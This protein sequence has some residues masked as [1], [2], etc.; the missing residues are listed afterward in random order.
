MEVKEQHEVL[1]K[2]KL[3]VNYVNK[4]YSTDKK[5]LDVGAGHGSTSCLLSSLG[6]DV[7][8]MDLFSNSTIERL[9]NNNVKVIN[10]YFSCE[11][12]ISNYDLIVGLHC[13]GA[14]ELIIK[15]S[16]INDKEFLVTLC[17][18]RK[19]LL[20]SKR[21]KNRNDY[22]NYLMDFDKRIKR[23]DLPIYVDGECWGHTLYLKK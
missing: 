15:S 16:L 10:D 1:N 22:V 4:L 13:C 21:I 8:A 6:Y 19:D 12:D 23:H 14:I 18:T 20:D 2:Y 17:E 9:S 7:S 5:I 11:T 3:F